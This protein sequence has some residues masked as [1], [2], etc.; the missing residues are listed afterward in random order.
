MGAEGLHMAPPSP[1]AGRGRGRGRAVLLPLSGLAVPGGPWRAP[2]PRP[3]P[4]PG[5][6]APLLLLVLAACLLACQPWLPTARAQLAP[7]DEV[8]K[9][10]AAAAVT[11]LLVNGTTGRPM[12]LAV[13]V[14]TDQLRM[15]DMEPLI[16]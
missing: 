16:R 1:C 5:P 7:V 15:E 4:R 10:Q 8:R 3:L 9:T 6:S 13:P 14:K 11:Q 12:A 2:P